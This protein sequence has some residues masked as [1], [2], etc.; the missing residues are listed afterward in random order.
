MTMPRR[1]LVDVTVTCYYRCISRCVRRAFLCGGVFEHRKGWIEEN[2]DKL[3][4]LP[5]LNTIRAAEVNATESH[6]E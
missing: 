1:Q 2:K 5:S 3:H 4:G 6:F